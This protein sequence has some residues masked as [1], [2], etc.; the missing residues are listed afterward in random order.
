MLSAR[1]DNIC[2]LLVDAMISTNGKTL[3]K[4]CPESVRLRRHLERRSL[5]D[6][7]REGRRGRSELI[8]QQL[9]R[10]VK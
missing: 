6:W 1:A 10:V 8:D 2:N 9:N 4:K 3:L 7:S 5:N